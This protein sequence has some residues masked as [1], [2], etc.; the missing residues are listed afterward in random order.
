MSTDIVMPN[1]GFD[2][3]TG[4]LFEWL[5]QPGETVARGE[6]IAIIESDKA[7]V[8]LESVA[9]GVLLEVLVMPGTDVAVGSVIA[10]V[11]T[12]EEWLRPV[13]SSPAGNVVPD[14]VAVAEGSRSLEAMP[15]AITRQEAS[16]VA[17]KLAADRGVDLALVSGSGPRGRISR[18]DVEAYLSSQQTRPT[19]PARAKALPKVRKAAREVGVDLALV[20]PRGNAGIITMADL[21]AY[22]RDLTAGRAWGTTVPVPE[23]AP[24]SVPDDA[25]EVVLSR[26]RQVIGRRLGDSMREAP[27]FYVSGEFDLEAAIRRIEA[28]P[29]PR[30]RVNDLIQYLTVQAVLRVPELNATFI[31]GHLYRHTSVNLAVAVSIEDGL[32]TPVIHKADRYSISGLA[33]ESAE[34][35][36]RARA[37]RLPPEALQGGSFTISNLGVIRQVDQFTAVINPP[38]VAILAVG[39]VRP[40]PVVVDSGLHIRRT[41]HLTLSGDH[42]VVDGMH[43]G[44]FMVAFQEELDS[45]TR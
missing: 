44:K 16:P 30:L 3:Q 37:N 10:R 33:A 43:L 1:L 32:V 7:N 34:L 11:G 15:P 36:A 22:R 9:A 45:F 19:E 26:A 20:S 21:E 38:Q 41:V 31:N 6:A 27:H 42:R 4:V 18:E 8:E 13:A 39:T 17:R 28:K 25:T 29:E 12:Q 24:A 14:R 23:V 40:R 35:I 2:T 5:K